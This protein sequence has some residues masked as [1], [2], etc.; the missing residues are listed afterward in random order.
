MRPR[1]IYLVNVAW[2][3]VEPLICVAALV[4]VLSQCT[5][6]FSPAFISNP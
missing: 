2:R 6:D 3:D 5:G 4:L 1:W